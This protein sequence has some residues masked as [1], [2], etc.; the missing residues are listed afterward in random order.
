M[1]KLTLKI[2]FDKKEEPE[3][4]HNIEHITIMNTVHKWTEQ[5]SLFNAFLKAQG[6]YTEDLE[7]FINDE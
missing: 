4:Y 3:F 7:K 6:F 2:E 5:L 1:E